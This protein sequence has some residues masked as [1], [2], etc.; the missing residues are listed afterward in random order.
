MKIKTLLVLLTL[1]VSLEAQMLSR[2]QIIMGTYITISLENK[3]KQSIEEAFKIFKEVDESIS[4]YN[5]KSD[6]YELNK[7]K[8]A[9]IN[10]ITY[11]ALI[12]SKKYYD[13]SDSYFD[14]TIGSI[15]KDLYNFGE[16]ERLPSARELKNASIDFD[17]L[18]FNKASASI[19]KDIKLDLGGMGKGFAVDKVS[20]FFKENNITKAR[21]AASGDIR[22]LGI[23][24]IEVQDPFSDGILAS[25]RTLKSETGISTSGNYN[26]YVN[27][28]R[29][30]HLINPK[31]KSS[32]DKFVSITL[33]SEIPSSDLDAYATASSVM[34]T[35]KAFDFLE[36]FD[37]AYIVLKSDGEL[38]VSKNIS[39]FTK[40]LVWTLKKNRF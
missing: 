15:T 30:N 39:E 13:L 31:L 16:K 12:L 26:R 22:C 35:S 6:I 18:V 27:S 32:Q 10:T 19:Q 34:P 38:R 11:E 37:L 36:S 40:N 4:S 14:I 3:E 20:T 5:E 33:I 21:I 1:F 24:K 28:V 7:Y 23:C 9:C 2:T 29:N 25:F 17:G 8:H